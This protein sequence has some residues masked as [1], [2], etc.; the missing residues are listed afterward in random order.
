MRTTGETRPSY[1]ANNSDVALLLH[2]KLNSVMKAIWLTMV[3]SRVVNDETDS[4]VGLLHDD[5]NETE[6]IAANAHTNNVFDMIILASF[7][8]N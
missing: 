2:F 8:L 4:T 5:A 3:A 6:I 7:V 1:S